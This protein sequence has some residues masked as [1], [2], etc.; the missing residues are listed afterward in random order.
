MGLP[1]ALGLLTS[2]TTGPVTALLGRNPVLIGGT[3]SA[4]V[5]FIAHAVAQQGLGGAAKVC[6]VA[7][8][9]MMGFGVLGLGR[10]IQRV[11]HAVVTG[12][13]C[14][15][16]AMMVLSQ[17]KSMLGVS[18][19]MDR[20]SN[21]L[22]YHSWEVIHAT[23]TARAAPIVVSLVVI[24]VACLV[25]RRTHRLPAPLLGVVAAVVVARLLGL[26]E[27]VVGAIP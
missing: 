8:V 9:A 5:P 25:A 22:L 14:G 21:N 13:S 23:G 17:L 11:P 18:V 20:A 7:A 3:A 16:G 1:P 24:A 26:D 27:R 4:T 12:F 10:Y 2:I 19:N 6:L 15:I